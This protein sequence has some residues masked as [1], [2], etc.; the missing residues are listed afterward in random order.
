MYVKMVIAFMLLWLVT[1]VTAMV[2]VRYV[3]LKNNLFVFHISTP[4]QYIILCT[5][6]K[7]VILNAR[8]KRIIAVSIFCFIVLSIFFSAFIQL[9]ASN[10]SYVVS[11]ESVIMIFLSL[12]YLREILLLQQ[13]TVLHRFPMFWISIGILFYFTGILLIEGMLNYMIIHSMELAKRSYMIEN[14]FEY[15]LFVLFIIGAFCN[16]NSLASLKKTIRNPR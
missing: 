12:Y 9:P 10:N 6:Y 16:K 1:A 4:I 3:K 7:S 5:L 13:V 8:I 15:L 2:L 14:L 11:I